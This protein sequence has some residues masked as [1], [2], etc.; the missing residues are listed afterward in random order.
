MVRLHRLR[1][2][3][4]H[5]RSCQTAGADG[6]AKGLV[7][8]DSPPGRVDKV[9][10]GLHMAEKLLVQH[11]AALR[12][13]RQVQA[14]DVAGLRQ[15]VQRQIRHAEV[16]LRLP[17]SPVAGV[18]IEGAA[19]GPQP[20]CRRLSDGAEAN[21]PHLRCAQVQ[22][23]LAVQLPLGVQL[24]AG[25]HHAV[26]PQRPV[27]Q[28]G[29]QRNGQLRHGR[30]VAAGVVAHIDA[31]RP[32]RLQ[33]D[34]VDA[35]ALAVDHLQLRQSGDQPLRDPGHRRD[36]QHLRVRSGRQ[37]VLLRTAAVTEDQLRLPGDRRVRHKLLVALLRRQ[38]QY[39]H[40]LKPSFLPQDL[41]REAGPSPPP[42][43]GPSAHPW[44]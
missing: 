34:A 6:F 42:C 28:H 20:L 11:M 35:H 22:G 17:V 31:P 38:Y 41:H 3:G 4:V 26:P 21:E 36:K 32:G 9:G 30:R 14:D 13:G 8:D 19:I 25:A 23:N 7:I 37:P 27:G 40:L 44:A 33:I 1:V 24:M 2:I 12:R 10:P 5:R 43:P 18:V 39:F 15:L 16:L 29:H